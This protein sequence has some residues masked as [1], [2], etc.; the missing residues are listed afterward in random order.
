METRTVTK[1]TIMLFERANFQLQNIF[2]NTVPTISCILL[3]TMNKS[4]HAAFIN[5]Y[6]SGG[7]HCCCHHCWNAPPTTSLCSHPL[8]GLHKCSASVNECQC[9]Q[10]FLCR[11]IQ[12]HTFASYVLPC[13]T[14]FCQ[15]APLLPSATW[16]RHVMKYWWEGSASTSCPQHLPLTSWATIIK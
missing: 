13:Q 14:P 1:N 3:L 6:S 8:F 5:T 16:Q 2:F 7:D 9:V 11:G 10:F 4:L 12:W 15:T